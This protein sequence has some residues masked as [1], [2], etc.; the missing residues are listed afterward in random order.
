M[1]PVV[2][3]KQ[4]PTKPPSHVV[5][6]YTLANLLCR[7]VLLGQILKQQHRQGG[8]EYKLIHLF[9]EIVIKQSHLPKKQPCQHHQENRNGGIQTEYQIFHFLLS[10]IFL[11]PDGKQSANQ[12]LPGCYPDWFP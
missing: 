11:S 6:I 9:H 8:F 2:A 10:P 5:V 3:R 1:H 7:K 4:K 12:C